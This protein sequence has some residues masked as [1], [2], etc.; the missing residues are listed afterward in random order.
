MIFQVLSAAIIKFR[1]FWDV[2]PCSKFDVKNEF[3][4]RLY[5]PEDSVLKNMLMCLN[6]LDRMFEP[7][8]PSVS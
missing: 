4:T 7:T 6:A 3:R 8:D 1:A 5:I 2:L